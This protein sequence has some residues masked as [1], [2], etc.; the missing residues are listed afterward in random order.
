MS[1]IKNTKI[2]CT[3]GPASSSNA[4]I[5]KMVDCGMDIARINMSHG[6][7]ESLQNIIDNCADLRQ[8]KNLKIMIDTKG[9]EIRIGTFENG[10]IELV[11]GKD[12]TFTIDDII[13]NQ[14][15]VSLKYKGLINQVEVG[16]KILANNGQLSL[17]VV[18]KSAKDIVCKVLFGGKLSNNKG[19]NVPGVVPNT[20]YLSEVDKKDILFG[21]KNKMDCL[22][23]SFVSCAQDVIDVKKFLQKNGGEN[24]KIFAK[25][26][27][28]EGVKNAQSILNE[29]DGLLVARGDLGVE[30]PLEKLPIIQKKLIS[31]CNVSQK[32]AIVA[33]E[34]LESMI[35]SAR[36]TRAE[37]NDVA[38]AIY[39]EANATMLSGETSIGHNP[40]L[41][42]K[43]MSKIIVEVEKVVYNTKKI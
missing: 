26:E 37:V 39:D 3:L 19:L 23:L 40:V 13:G 8:S 24:V 7:Y 14:N 21:L 15:R 20:P 11:K 29:C 34:M 12:F 2:I 18:E 22:S 41:A 9:P 38:N 33:T 43:T 1:K 6:T 35:Y 32:F 31:I 25:I 17:K 27:N 30:I 28:A 4:I 16:D 36:P 10:E 5:S 42:V